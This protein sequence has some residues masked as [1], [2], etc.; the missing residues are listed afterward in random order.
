MRRGREWG[1]G[2]D[3]GLDVRML[4]LCKRKGKRLLA[5]GGKHKHC[6]RSPFQFSGFG[7]NKPAADQTRTNGPEYNKGN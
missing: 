4:A 2:A 7:D 5:G 3:I 1:E 6:Q